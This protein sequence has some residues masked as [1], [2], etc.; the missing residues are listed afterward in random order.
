[1][2]FITV[3]FSCSSWVR[4]ID[5]RCAMWEKKN[6]SSPF[7]ER[8]NAPQPNCSIPSSRGQVLRAQTTATDSEQTLK[9]SGVQRFSLCTFSGQRSARGSVR[10]CALCVFPRFF[11][12]I[13][14]SLRQ[15][16]GA[17]RGQRWSDE[18][19]LSSRGMLVFS[20]H[21]DEVTDKTLGQGSPSHI[22]WHKKKRKHKKTHFSLFNRSSV[23]I[24]CKLLPLTM[25]ACT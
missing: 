15:T 24:I 17:I 18:W 22:D 9:S 5:S 11:W 13:D 8:L 25:S 2:F 23:A 6:W 14:F 16:Q 7:F 1:M 10:D 20:F 3:Y 21:F 4:F 12:D 19:L